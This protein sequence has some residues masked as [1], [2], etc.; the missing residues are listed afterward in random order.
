MIKSNG[1]AFPKNRHR[2]PVLNGTE[3]RLH[4]ADRDMILTVTTSEL[5]GDSGEGWTSPRTRACLAAG[6]LSDGNFKF[7]LLE[8]SG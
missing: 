5:D 7:W 8:S 4:T 2:L 6:S 3:P 1:F